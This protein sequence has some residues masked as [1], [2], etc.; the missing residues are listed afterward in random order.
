M[1]RGAELGLERMDRGR[2][3]GR[4]R[5]GPVGQVSDL[6]EES[7]NDA[8]E[9]SRI[10]G[11]QAH[12]LQYLRDVFGR[13]LGVEDENDVAGVGMQ[14]DALVGD[15]RGRLSVQGPGAEGQ[16]QRRGEPE[17]QACAPAGTGP[18]RS[19]RV[20]IRG[21]ETVLRL[22]FQMTPSMKKWCSWT[23]PTMMAIENSCETPK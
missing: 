23:P 10:V 17:L 9:M 15:A 19:E 12:E 18:A 20:T 21:E 5:D 11:A 8:Q 7:G 14:D 2:L 3:D 6:G 1:A 16:A 13:G 22:S 4:Q